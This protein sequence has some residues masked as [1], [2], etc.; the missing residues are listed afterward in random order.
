[1]IVALVLLGYALLIAILV[2]SRL[3]GAQWV[4]RAPRLAIVTWQVLS[5]TVLAA[6]TMAGV[7]L[8]VPTTHASGRLA[9]FL[10][11]CAMALRE[12]Y[13]S[14]GG[15]FIG[16]VGAALALAVIGRATWY[17]GVGVVG[18]IRERARHRQI[19][20]MVG[21]R[22]ESRGIVILDCNEPTVY[23][24]PG[25]RSRTVVTTAALRSLDRNQLDA[26]LAHERAHLSERHDI[27]V[28]FAAALATAFS[29]L[30]VFRHAAQEIARLVEL[31]A[32]DIAATHSDRLTVAEA[33]LTVGSDA[34][35]HVLPALA[36]VSDN[37]GAA[38][39]RRLIPPSN[40]LGRLQTIAGSFALA[41]LIALPVLVLA[42]PAAAAAQQDFCP[43]AAISAAK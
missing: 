16:A 9:E 2:P 14:P 8:L 5:V 38:R 37:N 40:P 35:L 19:L 41:G 10:Q 23:C 22:D 32:D 7:A 17:L 21:R 24:L 31:R 29:A 30:K 28:A 15:V 11:A 13:A 6:I 27:A 26:V 18:M 39:V 43:V 4:E 33:L 25:R 34:R 42:G 36:L 3:I 1:M 20:D 12:Q